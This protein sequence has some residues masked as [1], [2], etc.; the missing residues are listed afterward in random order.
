MEEHNDKF[1][2]KDFKQLLDLIAKALI[3]GMNSDQRQ[4]IL[5][6]ILQDLNIPNDEYALFH[7]LSKHYEKEENLKSINLL[8]EKI[9]ATQ[10][11][12]LRDVSPE[13]E[14]I[15]FLIQKYNLGLDSSQTQNKNA[16]VILPFQ[17]PFLVVYEKAVKPAL[18]DLGC[19]VAKADDVKT[20]DS[21]INIIL[22][23]ITQARFLVADVTYRNPN[24]FYEIGYA[25]AVGKK[26][27]LLSQSAEDL[28]FDLRH[29][30]HIIYDPNSINALKKELR[31]VASNLLSL[32]S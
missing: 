28:P 19:V 12:F 5:K 22:S 9:Q 8:A 4:S 25:H 10:A 24:V 30:R 18:T 27:I 29:W 3:R 26:V 20:V 15:K 17:E 16:F 11:L 31:E 14:K 2:E 21:I 23:Q 13:L 6:D 7:K 32:K 1:D